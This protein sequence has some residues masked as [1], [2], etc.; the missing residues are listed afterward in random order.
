M[1]REDIIRMAR[2]AGLKPDGDDWGANTYRKAIERFAALVAT[3]L[4]AQQTTASQIMEAV[5]AEREECAKVVEASPS[6]DWH[7]FACEAAAAIRARGET[8]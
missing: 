3:H 8:K 6:Y 4:W 7:R 1:T 5:A 2:E